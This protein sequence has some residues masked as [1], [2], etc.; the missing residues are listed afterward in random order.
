MADYK[1]IDFKPY[2]EKEEK[3]GTGLIK[4]IGKFQVFIYRLSGG[5]LMN[6]FLG[7]PVA[8][9]THTG[10]KSGAI[11]RTPLVYAL[12]GDS[13]ILAGSKGGMSKPPMW[14]HNLD[15]NPNCEIQIGANNRLVTARVA[16]AEEEER[17][18]PLLTA[19]YA[20]FDEYRARTEGV[21]HINLY[22]LEP[23]Q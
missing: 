16:S 22:V 20:G 3:F 5:R 21:R 2:S 1:S 11:R 15:A 18:W 13:V 19:V 8:I 4:R 17:L 9:L 10:R 14:K 23:R 12:D 6:T 7:A